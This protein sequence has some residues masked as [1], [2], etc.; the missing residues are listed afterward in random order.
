MRPPAPCAIAIHG[1]AGTLTRGL[2]TAA[3]EDEIHAALQAAARAGARLLW[4]GGDSLDA[5][6]AAVRVLEDCVWLNLETAVD[7]LCA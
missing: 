1:G 4:Q 7:R 3:Q 2:L 5:V 6:E